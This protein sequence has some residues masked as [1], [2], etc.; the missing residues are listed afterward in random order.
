MP[1]FEASYDGA[2]YVVLAIGLITTFLSVFMGLVHDATSSA[3][4]RTRR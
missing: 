4:S 1:L 3:S 2:L